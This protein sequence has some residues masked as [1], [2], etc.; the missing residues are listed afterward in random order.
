MKIWS[1]INKNENLEIITLFMECNDKTKHV[2]FGYDNMKKLSKDSLA[3]AL[4]AMVSE[5]VYN[6]YE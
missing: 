4:C 1:E 5:L 2:A 6:V 3:S